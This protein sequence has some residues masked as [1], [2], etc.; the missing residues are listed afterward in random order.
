[1]NLGSFD[2]PGIYRMRGLRGEPVARGF[3]VNTPSRDTMLQRLETDELAELLGEGT[4]RLARTHRELESSIG[5]ARY[6]VELYPLVMLFVM[7]LFVIEQAMSNRFYQIR[8]R[9]YAGE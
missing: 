6:G 1:M 9:R 8:F 5:T 3:S 4:F 2:N 7:A